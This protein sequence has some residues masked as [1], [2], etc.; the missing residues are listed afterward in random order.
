[1]KTVLL[2]SALAL[3]AAVSSIADSNLYGFRESYRGASILSA[4]PDSLSGTTTASFN[5]ARNSERGR[6]ETDT[7]FHSGSNAIPLPSSLRFH[8]RRVS[9]SLGSGPGAA[10]GTGTVS[11]GA[12]VIKFSISTNFLGSPTVVVGRIKRTSRG[13][14]VEETLH[15]QG[16]TQR[17]TYN[18]KSKQPPGSGS[19][20][21]PFDLPRN[22]KQS[23][24]SHASVGMSW[25]NDAA[26]L[27]QRLTGAGTAVRIETIAPIAC[28]KDGTP[29]VLRLS[30]A[31]S[32]GDLAVSLELSGNSDIRKGS[33]SPADYHLQ[34]SAGNA[35]GSRI[36]MPAG[37]SSIDL[38]VVPVADGLHEVPETLT[39]SLRPD[40]NYQVDAPGSAVA[41]ICDATQDPANDNIF[42]AYL[43]PAA[44]VTS[45][46]SGV[47]TVHLRGDNSSALVDLTFSGLTTAQSAAHIGAPTSS[48]G[49]GPD[50]KG[51]PRGQVTGNPWTIAAVQFL[52]T[53]QAVL[54]ALY[55]GQIS[56]NV[57][58]GGYPDGEIRGN[59]VMS[60]GSADPP[61]PPDPPAEGALTGEALRR[62]VARFL[63]QATFGPTQAEIDALAADIDSHGG[64][65]IAGYSAW[66]DQQ[67]AL[68]QTR[69]L[70]YV[71]AADAQEWALRGTDPIN[72]VS[73]NEPGYSNRRRGWWTLAVK[74]SDALRQRVAFALSE[75]FVVSEFDSEVQNRH[76]GAANYYDLLGRYADGNYRALL[77]E[78]SRSPIMGKY[79]SSLKNQKAIVEAGTGKILVSPDENYA[80]EVMQLFSIGLVQLNADGSVKLSATGGPIPT[81]TNADITELARVLTG[82]SFSKVNGTKA[83]GYPVQ[84]NTNFNAG[85]G[86]LYFQAAWLN[87]MKNFAAYHDTGSK[88]VLG[89]TIPAGLSGDQDLDAA[90]DILANH[91]NAASFI[92]RRLIQRLVTSN[93]SAGYIYRV[94]K[95][96]ADD[97]A[98]QRGNL[99]AVVKAILLDHEARSASV[100]LEVSHGKQKEPILRYVQ[101]LRALGGA[102]ALPLSD[103]SA[104]AYPASQLDNF[105]AGATRYRYPG[106]D[107]QLA[108]TPQASPT[109][110]NWFLPDYSPS[111]NIAAAGLVAP[112]MQLTTETQVTQSI[113]YARAFTE[114][115]TGQGVNAL[116]GATNQ[117]LDDVKID[118]SPQV[119]EYKSLIAAGKSV[120]E[121]VTAV[122]DDLDLLL[123]GGRL[124]ERY[125]SAPAPNPR[126]IIIDTAVA[127]TEGATSN[128]RV[129]AIAYLISNSPTY[130]HQP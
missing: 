123:A 6:F 72:Y 28:E 124:K 62:D 99:K 114:S 81:Y 95:V 125:A 126:S 29:A 106:T 14:Q 10:T 68:E 70:D 56:M 23:G 92:A 115:D 48:G 32:L 50:I 127:T 109:V 119:N 20:D 90:L 113:N 35:F 33:A 67:F 101:L 41:T 97:G 74:A 46:A 57:L 75:I 61:V 5:A 37:T 80:R 60:S 93:P 91:P 43:A 47:S 17:L 31:S 55:S 65:R 3:G 105:P 63:M 27:A 103:L 15:A 96:F 54:D 130:I 94:A 122:V 13:L 66:I 89:T 2:A 4:G 120:T 34:D 26:A 39:V 104:Y 49:A 102:S 25:E 16:G 111:G 88:V 116:F 76:Y 38:K 86:P 45:S 53:D 21:G 12:D 9:L 18:L 22:G 30:R 85:Y 11:I 110:F 73:G 51:L 58:T 108:Q 82:W 87:P 121:A 83:A 8:G 1:M 77:G 7:V 79:L 40:P 52:T 69:L 129:K 78:V 44:G 36:V 19:Q 84:D 24:A 107:T 42:I 71:Q 64:D 112:E 117:T 98:A 59:Y 118:R 100:A 128:D